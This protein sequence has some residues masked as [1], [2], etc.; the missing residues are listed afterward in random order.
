MAGTD[1]GPQPCCCAACSW[2]ASRL[3]LGGRSVGRLPVVLPLSRGRVDPATALL[4]R[5]LADLLDAADLLLVRVRPRLPCTE[6]QRGQGMRGHTHLAG[7]AAS[8]RGQLCEALFKDRE[9]QAGRPAQQGRG[10]LVGEGMPTCVVDAAVREEVSVGALRAACAAPAGTDSRPGEEGAARAARQPGRSTASLP[11]RACRQDDYRTTPP[12][13]TRQTPG[14][15]TACIAGL[16]RPPCVL[17]GGQVPR[18]ALLEGL[19]GSAERGGDLG[20]GPQALG[21]NEV[22]SAAGKGG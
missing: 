20:L 5:L 17:T 15:G 9:H 19:E 2:L 12:P 4:L 7:S 16:A 8:G 21:R 1:K 11:G 14:C 3:E 6:A 18:L 22:G 10:R 13:V